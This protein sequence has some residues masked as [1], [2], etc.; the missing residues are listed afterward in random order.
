MLQVDDAILAVDSVVHTTKEH[1]LR[2]VSQPEARV[3]CYAAESED[4]AQVGDPPGM[5]G[6]VARAV[7]LVEEGVEPT[8]AEVKRVGSSA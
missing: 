3:V 2:V 4:H 6:V 7:A 8:W 5:S 1:I